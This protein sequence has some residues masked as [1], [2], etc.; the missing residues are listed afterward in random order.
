MKKQISMTAEEE[1]W[2][3]ITNE[4]GSTCDMEDVESGMLWKNAPIEDV[5]H[6]IDWQ[7]NRTPVMAEAEV[8]QDLDDY[9][10]VSCFSFNTGFVLLMAS[11]KADAAYP[12]CVKST[13]PDH[14]AGNTFFRDFDSMMTY[15]GI[16]LCNKLDPKQHIAL[17]HL[18]S[19]HF[20]FGTPI[21]WKDWQ[22]KE[23]VLRHG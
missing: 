18:Y 19:H 6:Y 13:A 5:Q 17:L 12:W 2:Y 22:R 21:R 11:K 16:Y 9:N 7:A 10:I 8:W 4:N 20:N 1:K 3:K 14:M 23:K 15:V